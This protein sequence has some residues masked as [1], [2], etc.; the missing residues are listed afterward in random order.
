MPH[1]GRDT[2]IADT[3]LPMIR[4]RAARQHPR[5]A[6]LLSVAALG[7]GLAAMPAPALAS[8]DAAR[9]GQ[10]APKPQAAPTDSTSEGTG[11]ST[12]DRIT[13]V[14]SAPPCKPALYEDFIDKDSWTNRRLAPSDCARVRTAAPV[15]S[16][17][18]PA[19]RDKTTPWIFELQQAG[20][21]SALLRL[22]SDVP[23]LAL[24]QALPTGDYTWAVT[25]RNRRGQALTSTP[26]RFS[27]DAESAAVVFPSGTDFAAL[28]AEHPHPRLLPADSSFGTI[29][30]AAA[31]SAFHAGA[32]DALIRVADRALAT[33]LPTPDASVYMGT[34]SN[35]EDKRDKTELRRIVDRERQYIEATGL[36]AGFTGN[37][38]YRANGVKRLLELAAWSPTGPTSESSHDYANREIYR[39]LGQG[40]TLFWNDLSAAQKSQVVSSLKARIG[41]A[42]SRFDGLD[43]NPYNSH[44]HNIAWSALEALMYSIGT[45]GFPEASSWLARTWGVVRTTVN[46][47]GSED[48]G[49]GNGVAYAWQRIDHLSRVAAAIRVITGIELTRDP[50]VERFGDF[51]IAMTAPGGTHS[52]AFGDGTSTT[53]YRRVASNELRLY[54]LLTGKPQHAWYAT[55]VPTSTRPT[56]VEPWHLMLLGTG[57]QAAAPRAPDVHAWHFADAG[58]VAFHSDV[59]SAE[60][61]SLF[62]R[63]SEFGSYNH[64]H[65]DQNAITFMSRG[66]DLLISG[67]HYPYYMSP[68]HAAVNRATRYKN[69]LTFDGGIGQ[70]EDSVTLLPRHSRDARG[71]VLNVAQSTDWAVATG[72][73]TLA[74]RRYDPATRTW[75]PLLT[76][77]VR[78]AAYNATAGV[79]VLYDWATSTTPRRWELNFNAPTPV[80]ASGRHATV[81]NAGASACIDIYGPDGTFTTSTGFDVVPEN[82]GPDQHQARFS[83]A[84]ASS[85]LVA[86]TVLREDCRAVDVDV[87]FDGARATVAVGGVPQLSFDGRSATI[88]SPN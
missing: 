10:V 65:A 75:S 6:S 45:P 49:F 54:A 68:H 58:V 1:G 42:M 67:G 50:W 2:P 66:R 84:G 61:S 20:A 30:A 82:D 19:N 38:R 81:A 31:G 56:Y 39:A 11:G 25:Y 87:T 34:V 24:A 76:N 53:H 55:A 83:A 79:A 72:D 27:V 78:S 74:Y 48:G 36:A 12:V 13:G 57:A 69:A 23:R 86:I 44:V 47:W 21:G 63:S 59:G 7:L 5:T 60:R 51:L 77:A 41:Q 29:A 70:A 80:G 22:E 32:L 16:W 8:P 26:R 73:A 3:A 71:K 4:T 17:T 52:N 43:R 35:Y 28:A 64:S 18:Q 15:F 14:P 37:A 62:F 88:S 9:P 85:E 46:T 40:L 33:P